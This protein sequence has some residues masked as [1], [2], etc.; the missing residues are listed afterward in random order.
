MQSIGKEFLI[1]A[2]FTQVSQS[3]HDFTE[4]FHPFRHLCSKSQRDTLRTRFMSSLQTA[5][6]PFDSRGTSYTF[7]ME[8]NSSSPK[9]RDIQCKFPAAQVHRTSK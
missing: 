7:L 8:Q 4:S 3:F 9:N 2:L 6:D 1:F 5:I